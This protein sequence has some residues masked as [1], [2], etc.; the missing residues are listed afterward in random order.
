VYDGESIKMSNLKTVDLGEIAGRKSDIIKIDFLTPIEA[1]VPITLNHLI[2]MVRRRLILYVNEYGEGVVPDYKCED[3]IVESRWKHHRL[4]HRSKRGGTGSSIRRFYGYTGF[5]TYLVHA[6]ES[7]FKL[8][9][10]GELIGAGAKASFGM[11]F[12]KIFKQS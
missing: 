9:S 8:L 5:A 2:H 3:K 11:G 10:I 4:T 1:K 12:F 7:A 6:D